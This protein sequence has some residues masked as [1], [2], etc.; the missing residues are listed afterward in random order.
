MD[1]NRLVFLDKSGVNRGMNRLY[2]WS[3][4]GEQVIIIRSTRGKRLSFVGAMA[5]DG[6]RTLMTYAG[7]MNTAVMLEFTETHLAPTL[8]SGDVV[9]MDGRNIHKNQTV[10]ELIEKA[11]ARVVILPAYSPE[12]NP[13]ECLWSTLKAK[14]RAVGCSDWSTLANQVNDI[15]NKLSAYF[16]PSWVRNCG[17]QVAPSA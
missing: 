10:R 17:Y 11:G 6:P 16:Y 7:T 14:M 13:I 5:V 12:L 8:R 15:W 4:V 2:G 3:P 9:V 1:T